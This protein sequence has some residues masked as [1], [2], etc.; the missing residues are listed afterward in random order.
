MMS[1]TTD[2]VNVMGYEYTG[3]GLNRTAKPSEKG[4]YDCIKAAYNHLTITRNIPSDQI[5]LSALKDDLVL[6]FM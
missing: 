6:T 3:Y 2:Q 1:L 5:I 4:C